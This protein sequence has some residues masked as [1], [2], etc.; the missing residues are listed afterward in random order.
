MGDICYQL[1]M[2]WRS[3]AFWAPL[4]SAKKRKIQ[5]W[6]E[7]KDGKNV[8]A[9][10]DVRQG[11]MESDDPSRK[12]KSLLETMFAAHKKGGNRASGRNVLT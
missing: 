8:N 9:I 2:W 6:Q 5:V 3:G 7:K 1:N 12:L 10:A 4:T 11:R